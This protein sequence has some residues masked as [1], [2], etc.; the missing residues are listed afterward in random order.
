MSRRNMRNNIA[1]SLYVLGI[2][3]RKITKVGVSQNVEERTKKISGSM[4]DVAFCHHQINFLDRNSAMRIE[5]IVHRQLEPFRLK[6]EWFSLSPDTVVKIID[7]L[8]GIV[9]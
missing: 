2:V 6:G 1:V 9:V 7:D 3:G 5:R 8:R 4:P